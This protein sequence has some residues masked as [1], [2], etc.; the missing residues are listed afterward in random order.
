MGRNAEV[1]IFIR[2]QNLAK[3]V[4][5]GVTTGFNKLKNAVFSVQGAVAA[6][7]LYAVKR[8]ATEWL[9]AFGIQ[10]LAVDRLNSSLRNTFKFT[11]EN[12]KAIQA[13]ASEVQRLTI[14]GDEAML[15][16]FTSLNNLVT[17][18]SVE[19]LIA[20]RT[21][22]VGLADEFFGGD[23]Q[24]AA[25]M[26]GKTLSSQVNALTRYGVQVDMTKDA[27]G[28]LADIIKS[29]DHL[30]QQ[31][32]ETAS[33]L[34]NEFI[35]LSNATGDTKEKF[36]QII[37][38]TFGLNEGV[39]NLTDGV[40]R[41]N[42]S[43]DESMRTVVKW[44]RVIVDVLVAIF[45][46]LMAPIRLA[47]EAGNTIGSALDYVVMKLTE[48]ILSMVNG[49]IGGI[50][51]L[52]RAANKVTGLGI[53]EL[54][55]LP[56]DFFRVEADA[57]LER[58]LGHGADTITTLQHVGDAW[59]KAGED[60]LKGAEDVKLAGDRAGKAAPPRPYPTRPMLAGPRVG[61]VAGSPATGPAAGYVPGP[62]PG[63]D[64]FG[65][66]LLSEEPTGLFDFPDPTVGDMW[67]KAFHDMYTEAGGLNTLISDMTRT[68][69]SGFGDALTDAFQAMAEGSD[70][71]GKAFMAGMLGALGAVAKGFGDF[72]M[73]KAAA[74]VAE[75]ILNPLTASKNLAGAAKLT[76]AAV[77]MY[78]IAGGARAAAGGGSPGVGGSMAESSAVSRDTQG[79]ATLIIEGGFLDMNDP[80]Q[81]DSLARALQQ[82][83]G[84]RVTVRGR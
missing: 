22:I 71:A 36:G 7:G 32:V 15:A 26:L 39:G 65:D 64:V 66:L 28:R 47:W 13:A 73:A 68:T 57:A 12:S 49:A 58:F 33:S 4:V 72:F 75:A 45:K 18:L 11:I 69:I 56:A 46:T 35:Q 31:S 53:G 43:L 23:V 82:L 24:T 37:T 59:I 70:H 78:A 27:N 84:R 2:A 21:A 25:Q 16:A 42:E 77:G 1:K 41:F 8:L 62:R 51:W 10:Q 81:A 14:H 63:V 61:G 9:K 6:L 67:I 74:A 83:S 19:K 44:G 50:N 5:N 60:A 80:R 76:G 48:G 54:G 30:W 3:G 52:I 40:T 20:A 34:T 29:T 55:L 17:T 79:E 38:E